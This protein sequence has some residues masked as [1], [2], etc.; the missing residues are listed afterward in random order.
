[1]N[2]KEKFEEICKVTTDVLGLPE[3]CLG[4]RARTHNITLAR[5]IAGYI[6]RKYK[7]DRN[8]IASAFNKNRTCSYFYEREHDGKA[9]YDYQYAENYAKVLSKYQEMKGNNKIFTE[10]VMLDRHL[11]KA[12]LKNAL[13]KDVIFTIK[14]G[15]VKTELFS[16]YRNFSED[17]EN[18]KK[19]LE[20]YQITVKWDFI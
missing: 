8:I 9:K 20:L 6:G 5:Q 7:I 14:S 19:C 16:N 15:N 3:D 10:K 4:K 2:E 17:Y 13:K 1:M 11:K 12:G 18:I